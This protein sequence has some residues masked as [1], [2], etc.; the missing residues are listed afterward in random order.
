MDIV[1]RAA[2]VFVLLWLVLRVVGKRELS[3]MS[4]FEV[5]VL[6][7]LGDLVGQ[8]VM[9]EDYSLT[10]SA[11]AIFTFVLLSMLLSYLSWR[12]PKARPALEGNPTILVRGGSVIDRALRAERLPVDD[13]LEAARMNGIRDLADIE[14]AV[15]EIDGQIS[16]FTS[17]P[18]GR[19]G[20]QD[21]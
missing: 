21:G 18:A 8:T 19:D 6:V 16:F 14:L 12:F 2:V 20:H 3:E 7:V 15:L 5:V 9:Q 1:V 10:G 17:K 13:L 11:L 4:A